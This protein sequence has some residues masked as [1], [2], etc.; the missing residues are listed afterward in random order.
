MNSKNKA[1]SAKID[2]DQAAEVPKSKARPRAQTKA[3]SAKK[4]EAKP[5]AARAKT[6][7]PAAEPAEKFDFIGKVETLLVKGGAGAA[8]F[9]FG[10]RG[11]HGKRRSFRLDA[12]DPFTMNAMA[13]LVLAAHTSETKIGVRTGAEAEGVLLV[14]ELA[15]RPKLGKGG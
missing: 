4:A 14:T 11:R 2:T 7:K 5:R 9:E 3:K 1:D 6:A 10:L 13:H 12:A 15:S 8:G